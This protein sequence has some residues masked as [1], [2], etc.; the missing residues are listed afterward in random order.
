MDVVSQNDR[1]VLRALGRQ[2]MEAAA[3]PRNTETIKLWKALNSGRMERPMVNIDQL[4]HH[5]LESDESLM[6]RVTDPFWRGVERG[7]R[8]KLYMWRHFPVDMVIEP[9]IRIPMAVSDSG[10][11]VKD[12]EDV[13]VSDPKNDV[14]SHKYRPVIDEDTD[15]SIITNRA[16]MHDDAETNRRLTEGG[17]IFAGVA[18]IHAHG[19]SFHLGIWDELTKWLGVE[20]CYIMIKDNP[21]FVHALLR[22]LTDSLLAGIRR[23]NELQISDDAA[24]ICHCS[25]V[26]DDA[27]LPAPGEGKGAVTGNS[28]AFGLA[29]LF[30]VVS[31][32]VTKEFEMP[33]I[34]EL[35]REFGSIY[36]GCCEGLSDRLDIL[37]EIPNVRKISCSPWSDKAQFAE[38][39]AAPLILSYKPNPAFLA[40][41]V[42]DEGL[43]RRDLQE[44]SD[45][46]KKHGKKLEIILKD[47][48]TV[49]YQ[50]ERLTRWNQIAMEVVKA[51]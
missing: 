35:A 22:K 13:L 9:F 17:D 18:P 41:D 23:V 32:E 20:E 11:G 16:F 50:P 10:Y 38:R 14:V 28:W 24:N 48:S 21:E 51:W 5:E 25:Y 33:Y 8:R 49:R 2:Y 6:C 29:Q 31:P 36:Y 12:L 37:K 39:L 42:M 15:L 1:E 45:L 47:V 46:A 19:V 40:T 7:L 30:S 44:I 34:S 26:Y 3:E 43:I 27:F 4:P